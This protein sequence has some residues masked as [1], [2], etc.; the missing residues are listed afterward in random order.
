M[1][2]PSKGS[3]KMESSPAITRQGSSEIAHAPTINVK[4]EVKDEPMLSGYAAPSMDAPMSS[5]KR[6]DE[7]MSVDIKGKGRSTS[8]DISPLR[9][10]LKTEDDEGVIWPGAPQ[11]PVVADTAEVLEGPAGSIVPPEDLGPKLS[12]QQQAVLDMVLAGQSVFITGNAGTGTL[13][14][15]KCEQ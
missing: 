1:V 15:I 12:T 6:E 7:T 2:Q 3:Q 11:N 10:A 13:I 8:P 4:T 9:V 5:V 14:N